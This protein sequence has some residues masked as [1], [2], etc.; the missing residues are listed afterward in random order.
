[1]VAALLGRT[2]LWPTAVV[3]DAEYAATRAQK[4]SR[5][6]AAVPTYDPRIMRVQIQRGIVTAVCQSKVTGELYLGF[7]GGQVFAYRADRNQVVKVG[8]GAGTVAGLAVDPTGQTLV[9]LR[10]FEREAVVSSFRKHPDGSYRHRPDV[11]F[12]LSPRSWLTPV[13]PLGVERLVGLSDG[14]DLQIVDAASGSLRQHRRISVSSSA[15][16]WSA[17]LL[18]ALSQLP[19]PHSRL[20][21]LTHDG[22]RWIVVD[23]NGELLHATLYDWQPGLPGSSSLSSVPVSWHIV[24][25][26]IELLGLDRNGVVHGARFHSDRG[27]IELVSAQVAT[28]R[29]GYLAAARAGTDTVVGVSCDRID[30]L[31]RAADRFHVKAKMNVDLPTAVACFPSQ[32]AQETLVV[33]SDGMITHVAPPR[34]ARGG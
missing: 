30:W 31:D 27:T 20:M 4:R 24:P 2:K 12:S 1:V 29:G 13:L 5:G 8:E 10:Q 19:S 18:P 14:R 33:C 17:L 28:T 6:S 16:P 23:E 21:I 34:R 22:A 3:S 26:F 15:G 32:R 9:T 11:H 25:P 7:G